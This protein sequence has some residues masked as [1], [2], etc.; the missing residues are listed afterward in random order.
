MPEAVLNLILKSELWIIL[1]LKYIP[2]HPC[3][4]IAELLLESALG[5][6]CPTF[7]KIG[8]TIVPT[9][10]LDICLSWLHLKVVAAFPVQNPPI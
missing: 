1:R 7:G 6:T 8:A 9:I 2:Q 10:G 3:L 4:N 5:S